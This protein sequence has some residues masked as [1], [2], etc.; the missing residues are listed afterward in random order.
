MNSKHL[1]PEKRETHAAYMRE[2]RKTHPMTEEQRVKDR[3]RSYANVYLRRGKLKKRPCEFCGSPESQ[4]HHEDYSRP[5]WVH[6]FCRT[7]HLILHR[8]PAGML[9]KA[10]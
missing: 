6:W 4:M 9:R 8:T 2:W 1:S 7:C 10:A 3:A 5:L